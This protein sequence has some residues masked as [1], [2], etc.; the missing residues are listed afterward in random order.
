MFENQ[1]K[2]HGGR[3]PGAG[4]KPSLTP[5]AIIRLLDPQTRADLVAITAHQRHATGNPHLSQEQV[6]ADLIYTAH[7]HLENSTNQDG[8][9]SVPIPLPAVTTAPPPCPNTTNHGTPSAI[10]VYHA[11]TA[12]TIRTVRQEISDILASLRTKTAVGQRVGKRLLDILAHLIAL[13]ADQIAPWAILE[14]LD[15]AHTDDAH[16]DQAIAALR[17]RP[18]AEYRQDGWVTALNRIATHLATGAIRRQ[19]EQWDFINVAVEI[20]GATSV[21]NNRIA[22]LIDRLRTKGINPTLARIND[23]SS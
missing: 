5:L 2:Q 11:A 1:P 21:T 18:L 3:R 4:R 16:R 10:P 19:A 23:G 15:R 7:R 6:V 20:S 17:Q 8:S 9:A 22:E 14:E 13:H 12:A